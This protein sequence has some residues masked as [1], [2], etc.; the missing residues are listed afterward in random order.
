MAINLFSDICTDVAISI[1]Y[2]AIETRIETL[3]GKRTSLLVFSWGLD[4][5]LV[6]PSLIHSHQF[7]NNNG[8]GCGSKI[9]RE[10]AS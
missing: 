9:I 10:Q 5:G 4:D 8:A 3:V 6:I 7:V 1:I 2:F